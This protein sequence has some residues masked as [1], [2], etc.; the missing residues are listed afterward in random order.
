MLKT[1]LCFLAPV[2]VAI[3]IDFAGGL[4]LAEILL[5]CLALSFVARRGL[6]ISKIDRKIVI[7]FQLSGI[8]LAGL[9]TSD[10]WNGSSFEQYSRGWARLAVFLVNLASIYIL[11]GNRR[12]RLIA[13]TLGLAAGR[14][15]LTIIDA[16]DITLNWKLG[17]SK[18]AALLSALF[19]VALYSKSRFL[20]RNSPAILFGLGT[21]NLLMDFR[22]LGGV[23]IASAVLLLASDLKN[24]LGKH[25]QRSS[26]HALGVIAVCVLIAT[27]LS[28][29]LYSH[30]AKSAWLGEAAISKFRAQ[31][32]KTSLPLLVAGRSE[33]LVSLEAIWD[34]PLLGHGSWPENRYYADKIALTRYEQRLSENT[35][36]P[37]TDLI[38][39]HS[40]LFGSWVE[41]GLPGGIFWIATLGLVGL[42]LTRS[43]DGYSAL[44]PLYV[45]CSVL[46]IWDILFSPFSGF[47]R[48]E[49]AYLLVVSIRGLLQRSSSASINGKRRKPVQGLC[50]KKRKMA[51][52]D[53][54]RASGRMSDASIVHE[55]NSNRHRK[56]RGE[57]GIRPA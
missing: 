54:R 3:E 49:T 39:T 33:L 56:R 53:R 7:I 52:A 8:Y 38:P 15:L 23:L 40:H 31:T 37:D 22:S 29:E 26:G 24:M 5:P 36:L 41:A 12:S 30:A 19:C 32:E 25:R 6:A 57:G 47:R 21:Y 28:F 51:A 9:I 45:Y 13:F 46:L 11:I 16:D 44:R 34:A 2:T 48:L 55:M 35:A 27:G 20:G 1:A 50:G 10:L 17:F 4:F 18:P 14:I 43:Y 42:T